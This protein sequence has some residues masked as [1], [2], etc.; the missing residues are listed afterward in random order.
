MIVK[1]IA[2]NK[3]DPAIHVIVSGPHSSPMDCSDDPQIDVIKEEIRKRSGDSATYRI[4]KETPLPTPTPAR[5]PQISTDFVSKILTQTLEQQDPNGPGTKLSEMLEKIGIKSTPNCSCK[6]RAKM[7]NEK[8][9][10]WCEQN[11]DTIVGWLKEE[12]QKRKLPFIDMAGKIIVK[13]AIS[14]SKKAKQNERK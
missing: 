9:Y 7:M 3:I 4:P 8:G 6:A 14:L 13:R 5:T 1:C 2:K 12:A 11:I 10:E